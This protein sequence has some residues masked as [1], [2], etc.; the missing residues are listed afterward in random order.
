MNTFHG[1]IYQESEID[2]DLAWQAGVRGII[3]KASEGL[4]H[5]D[6][7]YANAQRSGGLTLGRHA[8]KIRRLRLTFEMKPGEMGVR[9]KARA[10]SAPS[11]IGNNASDR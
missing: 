2:F 3:H 11:E 4:G 5:T 9:M 6:K 8:T 1:I 10:A 7:Q